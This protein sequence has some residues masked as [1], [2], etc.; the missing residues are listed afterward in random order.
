MPICEMI[1]RL[2][3]VSV[4]S[5]VSRSVAVLHRLERDHRVHVIGRR[6]VHRIEILRLTFQ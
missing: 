4:S 1:R 3:A 5:L 2:R 6:D